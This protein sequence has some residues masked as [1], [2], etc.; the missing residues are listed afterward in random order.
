MV[1]LAGAIWALYNAAY[2]TVISFVPLFLHSTGMA[3]ATATSVVGLGMWVAIVAGPLGGIVADRLGRPTL[4][5]VACVLIW[6]FGLM[7]VIPW[8][9]SLSLLVGLMFVA[10]LIGNLPAGPIVALASEVL[11]PQVRSTGMGIFYT[12]LY[13]GLGL[14]P[15]LAGFVS[16]VTGNPAAP[17]YL[18]AVL[19]VLTVL[20]LAL[21]RALQVR[22]FPRAVLLSESVA[23]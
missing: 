6:G 13:A 11:R 9:D 22:G 20:A 16:D 4:L 12:V 18:I 8:A 19:A 1:C 23:G 3:P 21:F 7:L 15:V 14:G 5:I 10:S 2:I 17:V